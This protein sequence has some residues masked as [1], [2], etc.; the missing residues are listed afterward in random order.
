MDIS[1]FFDTAIGS[2]IVQA[3]V[4]SLVAALLVESSIG[5]WGTRSPAWQLRLRLVAI[6]FPVF[7]Y[8][9][10]QLLNPA[11]GSL[12]FRLGALLDTRRW[13]DL[14]PWG[15]FPLGVLFV[16]LLLGT[17][18]L[19]AFQELVP[20]LRGALKTGRG[21][22]EGEAGEE[23][24]D[25]AG[26]EAALAGLPFPAPEME[27]IDDEDLVLFSSTGRKPAVFVST[28]LVESLSR[29][30]LQAAV[31]HE[32]AH[33][34]RSRRPLLLVAF[35]FRVLMFF[36]PVVL[37][38]FRKMVEDEE[39]VC[40]DEAVR[41]TGNPGA[42]A[43]TLEAFLREEETPLSEDGT[44]GAN[45]SHMTHAAVLR[46]RIARLRGEEAAGNPRG[47]GSWAQVALTLAAAGA[48]CYFIV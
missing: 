36:N 21:G 19:F 35:V 8:P 3:F 45:V 13:L 33:I 29:E 22:G 32:T 23:A 40:D 31:A 5:A 26:L 43:S 20:V 18:A 46:E 24:G 7:S 27:V 41:M 42:L 16:L 44:I 9:L 34:A 30:E 47:E 48:V 39:K 1:Y 12:S 6:L 2:Y 37:L 15:L 14:E 25:D 28:G 11:R 4:H 10:Y 17:V 38:E